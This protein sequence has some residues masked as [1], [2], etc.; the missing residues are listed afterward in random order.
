MD[1]HYNKRLSNV[2]V[3]R[4]YTKEVV[5]SVCDPT[6]VLCYSNNL[7]EIIARVYTF[8]LQIH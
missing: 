3:A 4:K 2:R 7:L 8:G 6:S 5:I 1:S